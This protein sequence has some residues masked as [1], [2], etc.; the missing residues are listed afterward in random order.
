MAGTRAILLIMMLV[1]LWFP[2]AHAEDI[3]A[4]VD[5]A[6]KTESEVAPDAVAPRASLHGGRDKGVSVFW[7]V[8]ILSLLF[9]LGSALALNALGGKHPPPGKGKDDGSGGQ[10]RQM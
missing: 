7:F 2:T 3:A 1:M 10:G 4:D 9:V 8:L 6:S 5:A